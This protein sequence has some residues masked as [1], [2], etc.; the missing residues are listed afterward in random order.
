MATSASSNLFNSNRFEEFFNKVSKTSAKLGLGVKIFAWEIPSL[1]W[2][3]FIVLR[4]STTLLKD[5]R[6]ELAHADVS[7]EVDEGGFPRLFEDSKR[8]RDKYFEL[9][10]NLNNLPGSGLIQKRVEETL[11]DWDDFVEDVSLWGDTEIRDLVR[12]VADAA[13]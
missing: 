2:D 12:E 9:Y 7:D 13:L 10:S 11:H 5:T 6:N 8:I 1:H 4:L 3:I